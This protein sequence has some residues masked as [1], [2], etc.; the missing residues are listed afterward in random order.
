MRDLL[1]RALGHTAVDPARLVRPVA[2]LVATRPDASSLWRRLQAPAAGGPEWPAAR[3]V[4]RDLLGDAIFQR[5]LVTVVVPNLFVERLV[6]FARRGLLREIDVRHRRRCV[7]AAAVHRGD[8][9]PMLQHRVRARRIRTPKRAEVAELR[10]AIT[11]A[12]DA[13]R[14]VPRHWYAVYACYRP[15]VTLGATRDAA[16]AIAEELMA[17]AARRAR[18]EAKS[19]SR[20]KKPGCA[21]RSR[22]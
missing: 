22:R 17:D 7:A 5:L 16:E 12:R 21:A 3:D 1:F 10:A 4:V 20:W 18:D 6:G 13:G 9:A 8:G 15:L 2:S 14:T 11:A 19:A